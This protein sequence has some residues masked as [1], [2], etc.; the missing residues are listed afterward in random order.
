M[1]QQPQVRVRDL[2]T[3]HEYEV[4]EARYKRT[5][6]LWERLGPVPPKPRTTVA[7]AAARRTQEPAPTAGTDA[8]HEADSTKEE[9]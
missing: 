7:Q 8:G 5:P 6:E 3:G 4:S 9:D 1:P 2:E